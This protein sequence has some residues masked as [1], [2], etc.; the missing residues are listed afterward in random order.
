[1]S[2]RSGKRYSLPY[3]CITPNCKFW[4]SDET[5]LKCSYCFTNTK[6]KCN[7]SGKSIPLFERDDVFRIDMEDWVS[8]NTIKKDMLDFIYR[9]VVTAYPGMYWK[10]IIDGEKL[11]EI[12]SSIIANKSNLTRLLLNFSTVKQTPEHDIEDPTSSFFNFILEDISMKQ[13]LLFLYILLILPVFFIIPLN[14]ILF[15]TI[16]V[17]HKKG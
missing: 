2:L 14:I 8:Q 5:G 17:Y 9:R 12:S 15:Y 1:M 13:L 11:N 7:V 3:K 16:L 10:N 4:G 6:T